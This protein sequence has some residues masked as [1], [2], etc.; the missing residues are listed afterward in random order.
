MRYSDKKNT[1]VCTCVDIKFFE[2]LMSEIDRDVSYMSLSFFIKRVLIFAKEIGISN[3]KEMG[4]F[5]RNTKDF[6][7]KLG[8]AIRDNA[9]LYS[10]KDEGNK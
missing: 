9:S 4:I 6:L 3:L 8:K 2:D 1:T 10:I 5:S 7:P